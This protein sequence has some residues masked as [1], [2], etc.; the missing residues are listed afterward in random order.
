MRGGGRMKLLKINPVRTVVL[1]AL[2]V[3]ALLQLPGAYR[4][5]DVFGTRPAVR[6]LFVG[7]SHTSTYDMAHMV[8]RI[9]D[10]AG[11]KQR[12]DITMHAPGG[13]YFADHVANDTVKD[14]LKQTWDHVVLQGASGEPLGDENQASFQANG[15]RLAEMA[16]ATADKRWLYVTWAYDQQNEWIRDNPYAAERM[17]GWVQSSY[18][19]LSRKTDIPLINIG[20][21]WKVVSDEK[22]GFSLYS[23]DGNHASIHGAYF[24]ALMMFHHL[25]GEPT[26][27]TTYR[28]NGVDEEQA[29]YLRAMAASLSVLL[30][31]MP[32]PTDAKVTARGS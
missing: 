21:A 31:R 29:A 11:A 20:A 22:P 32:A 16:R 14:L 28:P 4:V 24:T 27:A 5:F 7:N 9:A 19:K 12:Y 6:V 18:R 15:A 17:Q 3:F 8:R 1:G 25:S 23:A 2:L 30:Q 10:G 13:M 26:A